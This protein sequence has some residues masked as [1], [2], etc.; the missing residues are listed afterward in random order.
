MNANVL[1]RPTAQYVGKLE[2]WL[3]RG[4]VQGVGFRPFVYRAAVMC[5]L[6]GKVWNDEQ[7]V[8]LLG[9]GSSHQ[10]EKFTEQ[11]NT[12]IPPM[13]AI[14]SIEITEQMTGSVFST[15]KIVSSESGNA[16]L[17]SLPSLKTKGRT[18]N[19]KPKGFIHTQIPPDLAIC[20]DCLA[21][22][23]DSKNR[24][25]RYP[26][27]NCTHCGPRFTIIDRLPYDRPNTSMK[28]FILCDDCQSEYTTP[29][30]RRFHA[31]P[32]ACQQCG[33]TLKLYDHQGEFIDTDDATTYAARKINEGH[34][35]AIKATGGFQ[36]V[37]DATNEKTLAQLRLRKQRP[38]K[39]FAVMLSNIQSI[40]SWV[41][42]TDPDQSLL[43]NPSSPIVLLP[44]LRTELNEKTLNGVAPNIDHLGVMLPNSPL[45]YLLF[46]G[47]LG[48][49][50]S[51]RW[52]NEPNNLIWVV[53][54]GN[55]SGEPLVISNEA[56]L[57]QLNGIADYFLMHDRP[58][59]ERCDDSVWQGGAGVNH[60]SDPTIVRRARG[61]APSKIYL[62]FNATPSLACGA[63][64]KSTICLAEEQQAFMSQYLGDLEH[65]ACCEALE[66]SVD[67]Y[68]KLV[69]ITPERVICDQ[70]PDYFS[71]IFAERFAAE[72]QL[73]L[74]R[75]Q[76]HHAHIGAVLAE[77]N[78]SPMSSETYLG[79]AL[80]GFGLGLDRSPWGGELFHFFD[81]NIKRIGH[82]RP[83]PLP[84]GDKAA[85]EPWRMALS[86]LSLFK[87]SDTEKELQRFISRPGYSAIQHMIKEQI[88]TPMTTSA[89]RW[90]DAAAGL[91]DTCYTMSYEGQAAMQLESLARQYKHR[92]NKGWREGFTLSEGV[93]GFR[94]S[95]RYL[96]NTHSPT[97]AAWLWH[98]TV[99]DGLFEWVLWAV[100]ET[101]I[102]QVAFGGGVMQNQIIRQGLIKRFMQVDI[103]LIL[104][105]T[106][107]A[108]DAGISLGQIWISH[109]TDLN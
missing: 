9:E 38:D 28:G 63:A 46:H 80:D 20:K 67:H 82:F 54:S 79:V 3:V 88:N 19:A 108:N 78:F 65:F 25:Y 96:I 91:L 12:N 93:L 59:L 56:A 41:S 36:L 81:A 7:G 32:N 109:F 51:I 71:S 40:S 23:L 45:H 4:C 37:C 75:V 95:L 39:P 94:P 105:Q 16:S 35:V 14:D 85:K 34:I 44:S 6:K 17:D 50:D 47:A 24:R 1:K 21:E 72:H 13:A 83:L 101:G 73:P 90:F 92:S 86:A 2:H 69:A 100:K 55:I 68:L 99:I 61:Y 52:L 64:L 62:P 97:E 103:S 48:C 89:G 43:R 76:H 26:F 66:H 42:I 8:H 107:P 106:I 30:N 77:N 33:P 102:N 58:I 60:Q 5:G 29:E 104:P 18:K 70:H 84:G 31:Q 53:T 74:H 11:F 10:W 22:M 49:P 57:N 87:D 98:Q 15:F 27:I